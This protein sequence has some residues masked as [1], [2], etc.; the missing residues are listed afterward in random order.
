MPAPA[1]NR[2]GIINPVPTLRRPCSS[3]PVFTRWFRTVAG[4]LVLSFA[5]GTVLATVVETLAEYAAADQQMV[6]ER[7]L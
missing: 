7:L 6:V 2:A 1:S 4:T 5:D 3:R